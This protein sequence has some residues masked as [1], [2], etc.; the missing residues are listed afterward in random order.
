MN[1]IKLLEKYRPDLHFSKGENF[2]P[3]DVNQY[4]SLCSLKEKVE[5]RITI[6]ISNAWTKK[7]KNLL[8]EAPDK[9]QDQ[10][11]H[12]DLAKAKAEALDNNTSENQYLQFVEQPWWKRVSWQSLIVLIISLSAI[13]F[14]LQENQIPWFIPFFSVRESIKLI[15]AII[16]LGVWC[17]WGGKKSIYLATAINIFA[18][19]FYA[20]QLGIAAGYAATS[21]MTFF[22]GTEIMKTFTRKKFQIAV[23]GLAITLV[24]N[25]LVIAFTFP[26][27]INDA[28]IFQSGSIVMGIMLLPPVVLIL[29]SGI[30]TLLKKRSTRSVQTLISIKEKIS[31]SLTAAFK[32]ILILT[33]FILALN[34]VIDSTSNDEIRTVKSLFMCAASGILIYLY[35]TPAQLN[36]LETTN[37]KKRSQ[38]IP[39]I[40][41]L[42]VAIWWLGS[43]SGFIYFNP[44]KEFIPIQILILYPFL[45][46]LT[47]AINLLITL[48]LV[49][50]DAISWFMDVQSPQ[51][52]SAT[53]VAIEKY[54]KCKK[55]KL[56]VYGR[57]V[58]DDAW[59]VLQYHYF[60]AFN[61]YRKT[62]GG[63]NNHEGDWEMV[64][65][66]L[67]NKNYAK[68][69]EAYI[70]FGVACSQHEN[71]ELRFW[72]SIEH[73]Q[74]R[75]I[76]YTALGSHAN[77]FEPREIYETS[78]QFSGI[79]RKVVAVLDSI[80]KWF[81]GGE[82]GTGLPP[83]KVDGNYENN[84]ALNKEWQIVLISDTEPK[85]V[86]Y[87]GLWGQKTNHPNESGP[88][89]PMWNRVE[90]HQRETRQKCSEFDNT[91][92]L[93][94]G[95]HCWKDTL[96]LEMT[97]AEDKP[98]DDRKR[99]L[100]AL[101]ES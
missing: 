41:L 85:W 57:V 92:R 3:M 45:F 65:V 26:Y 84:D 18:A 49:G 67:K 2:F 78:Y 5:Q 15:I 36:V 50:G 80:L 68:E 77:Y 87:K 4:I 42:G 98:I 23:G 35:F 86:N 8:R 43:F 22:S 94:W 59:A 97:T 81:H 27:L 70:P 20:Y 75:P 93:R 61:D 53:D 28:Y 32:V 74:E 34:L 72:E 44:P 54:K 83:E 31:P 29:S 38:R 79:T 89:G 37:T 1:N 7:A 25:T 100:Q 69:L 73:L 76:I 63:I 88:T 64:A 95:L 71:G 51:S 40:I 30:D 10:N 11:G 24:I 14:G 47:V 99:A 21:L 39:V 9:Y 91:V 12:P 82:E 56:F 101:Y 52:D 58:S 62:A 90:K 66:F 60:Y 17:F 55:E 6:D 13:I 46:I 19:L 16:P 48:G 33:I 96:L